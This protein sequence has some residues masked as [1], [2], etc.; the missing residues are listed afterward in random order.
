MLWI[1]NVT[2]I[3]NLDIVFV[4]TLITF[5]AWIISAVLCGKK[6]KIGEAAPVWR[7]IPQICKILFLTSLCALVF[8]GIVNIINGI[9]LYQRFGPRERISM[10]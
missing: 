3:I 4:I 7:K 5:A 1:Y 6:V 10:L 8:L 9:V 2:A